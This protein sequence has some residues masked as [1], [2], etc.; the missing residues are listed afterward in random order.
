MH[1]THT[2]PR[3]VSTVPRGLSLSTDN[4]AVTGLVDR[5]ENLGCIVRTPCPMDRRACRIHITPEG[6]REVGKAKEVIR[7][8]NAEIQEG[9]SE[10]EIDAYR[11][12]LM[13]IFEKFA[14]IAAKAAPSE[15]AEG[16]P[17]GRR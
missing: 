13:G 12:V 11:K 1:E 16:R 4:S 17:H 10:Q 14:R 9:F 7:K 6:L 2:V 3:T 8:V 15:D 5:L